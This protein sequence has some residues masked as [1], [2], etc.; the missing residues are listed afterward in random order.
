M[1]NQVVNG[2]LPSSVLSEGSAP[3]LEVMVKK[4]KATGAKSYMSQ[5]GDDDEYV[6]FST[7]EDAKKFVELAKQKGYP[8]ARM[9]KQ[10]STHFFVEVWPRKYRGR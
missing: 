2:K 6:F 8:K 3:D 10:D 1:I 9:I 7:S 5:Q 4:F